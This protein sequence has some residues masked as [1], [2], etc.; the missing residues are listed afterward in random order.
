MKELHAKTDICTLVYTMPCWILLGKE[1]FATKV[2]EKL[3]T[4]ILFPITFF[5]ENCA[6]RH[7]GEYDRTRQATDDNTIECA[8]RA[9]YTHPIHPHP[10][11]P[12]HDRHTH[13][14]TPPRTHAHTHTH[15][16]TQTYA[17]IHTHIHTGTH[18]HIHTHTHVHIHTH[19]H[20]HTHTRTHTYARIH[21]HAR[22]HTHITHTYTHVHTHAHT[23]ARTQN[24][25]L[26][27]FHGN[28][29]YANALL[30][31]VTYTAHL[32]YKSHV[33]F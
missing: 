11:T 2:A 32:F 6:V 23:Y 27:L 21:T 24:Y 17:R 16:Y 29:G 7:I 18:T 20:A 25:Y 31:F 15:A 8:F 22:T 30:F 10:H 9:E 26:L 12:T 33:V 13:T 19:T 3:K 4:H 28:N 5:F 14:H 1:L